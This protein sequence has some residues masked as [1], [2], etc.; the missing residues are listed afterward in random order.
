MLLV[1]SNHIYFNAIALVFYEE[2]WHSGIY[3]I[4]FSPL[5]QN[6]FPVTV[7][8]TI[9]HVFLAQWL[10]GFWWMRWLRTARIFGHACWLLRDFSDQV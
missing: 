10:Q 5:L 7:V 4:I 2:L 9:P 6:S 8:S 1:K 3:C